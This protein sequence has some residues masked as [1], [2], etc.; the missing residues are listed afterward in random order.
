M[1]DPIQV[2]VKHEEG[3]GWVGIPPSPFCYFA[4]PPGLAVS[5]RVPTAYLTSS[6]RAGALWEVALDVVEGPAGWV[7][8]LSLAAEGKQTHQTLSS[9]EGLL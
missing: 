1:P 3:R 2:G 5:P 4:E 9:T 6:R 7:G 8:W